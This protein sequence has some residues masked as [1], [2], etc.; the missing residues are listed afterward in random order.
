V[1]GITVQAVPSEAPHEAAR[2]EARR[3]AQAAGLAA[4]TTGAD[5]AFSLVLPAGAPS[6]TLRFE[7][8]GVV[9]VRLLSVYDGGED[10]AVGDVPLTAASTFDGR[11]VDAGG[12][13][14]AGAAV[15]L[16]PGQARFAADET[17]GEEIRARSGPDGRFS[18]ERAAASGNRLRVEAEG[19][20]CAGLEGLRAGRQAAPLVLAP[21]TVLSGLV[22]ERDGRTPASGALVRFEGASPSRWVEAGEDGRFQLEDAPAGT[23]RVVADGGTRGRAEATVAGPRKATP[24]TLVLAPPAVVAGRI[25]DAASGAPVPRARVEARAGGGALLAR[26]GVDGRDRIEGLVP[27]RYRV[28]ADE[29]RRV[30]N[31]RDEVLVEAGRTVTVDL[32]LS[33]GASL[34]GRVVDEGGKPVAGAAGRLRRGG[35]SRFELRRMLRGEGGEPIFRSGPDGTFR[36]ERLPAGSDQQLVVSHP[37]FERRTLAGLAL[38]AGGGK[39]GFTVVLRRGL[40][41]VGVVR[42]TE[43]Q[44]LA[45]AEIEVRPSASERAGRSERF[46]IEIGGRRGGGDEPMATSGADGRFRAAGLVPGAYALRARK[47]GFA[48]ADLDPVRVERDEP[49]PAVE[50][51]LQPGAAI[52]GYVRRSDGRGAKGY[53][54]RARPE[55]GGEG[56]FLGLGPLEPTGEDGAFAIDGLQVGQG[57]TLQLLGPQSPGGPRQTGVRAPAEDVEILVPGTGRITGHVTDAVSREPVP[58]FTVSYEPERPQGGPLMRMARAPRRLRRLMGDEEEGLVRS[59][60]GSFALEDVP[61]GTWTVT[62]EAQGYEAARVAGVSVREGDTAAD[63]E[64][65]AIKGRALRG[66]VLDGLSGRPVVGATVAAS[67]AEGGGPPIPFGLEDAA[68]FTDA[69]G[70]FEILGLGLGTFKL[71]AR[72]AEYAEASRLVELRQ[73][74]ADVEIRLTSGGSLAGLVVSEGGAPVGGASVSL[75]TAGGG[76]GGFRFGPGGGGPGGLGGSSTLSDDGGRFRFD[77]LSAGRYSVSAA[78]RGRSSTAIDVPLQA[79]ESREDLRVSLA[80]G[81]TIRGRVVGLEAALLGSVNVMADGPDG[82]FAGVRPAPDGTFTLGG[83]PPGAIDLR[84]MAGDFQAGMRTATAQVQITQGQLEAEADIVFEA[85]GAISGRITRGGE[86]VAETM[87]SVSGA[88]GPGAFARS[89]A[90]GSYRLEG[91]RDG[92]Y[93]V[94]AS[95]PRGAPRRQTVEVSG[96]ASL[97]FDLPLAALL[98]TVAE[99]GSGLPLAGAEVEVETGAGGGRGRPRAS[100]D[101]NGRFALEGLEPGPTTLTARRTGYVFE[102]RTVEAREEGGSPVTIELKRGEGLGLRARDGVFGVPLH[103]LFAQARDAAGSVAFGGGISLDSDGRG[104]VPSLRPGSYSLRLDASGYAPLSLSVTVPSPTL[105]VAFTPGGALEIRSG[106]DTQARA[107]RARLLDARGTPVPQPPFGLEGWMVLSGAVKRLE[108]LAP[109][110]YTVVVEGGPTK[111]ANVTEGGEAVVEL[112]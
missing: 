4:A 47:D 80:A 54:V 83:V 39:S 72:H 88:G 112:P 32:P 52:R 106:P 30:P 20:A 41:L 95:P 105:E 23:G 84:A 63:V 43:G 74:L 9:P 29:P 77:R 1:S 69:D 109:G 73:A 97:D 85:S 2:R 67:P 48:E 13:P 76:A 15:T 21:A 99:A 10:A 53:L 6:V 110:G 28:S 86:A 33:L 68:S 24:L 107:P 81:A 111:A 51:K 78:L 34:S 19:F 61:A 94:T 49:T 22:H 92:Q 25:V 87:V 35:T 17:R 5:G 57:Y 12:K 38:P 79:G 46:M 89:D 91:L 104:E 66:R 36:A 64:V 7:G 45:G 96:E 82:Y 93:T 102:K 108:H 16:Q 58:E 42:D 44:P 56:G 14:V 3:G 8:P 70:R 26:S 90:A 103:G 75:Q 40:E 101:C 55:S 27:G 59:E 11:V 60:D 65:R 18:F 100:T 37:E 98:G 50:L 62:V 71:V 31:A